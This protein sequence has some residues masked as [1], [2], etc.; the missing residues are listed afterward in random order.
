MDSFTIG[1]CRIGPD[2]PTFVIA[3]AG[4][5]H[6]GD[7]DLAKQL[8]DVA[9]DAGADAVKFQTFRAEDMYVED[10]G[11]VEYLDDDRSI[12]EIIESMEMPYE[13]IPELHEYCN[14]RG[15]LF[16]STPF[17]ERSAGELAEYVPAWKVASY[18]SSHHP[19]LRHLA[20]TE[21]PVIMSTGAHELGEVAESVDVLRE[22]GVSDLALLQCVAAYPTPLESINVRVVETLREQFGVPAGLSDHTLDPTVAPTAAVALGAAIIEKHFT[23]DKNMEGPDHQFALEP[24][25]LDRMVTAIRNT[26]KVLGDGAKS[27]LDVEEE[28]YQKARRS[29][30]AA[31]DIAAGETISR[32]DLSVLR[33]GNK[34]KGIHPKFVGD[35]VGRR[36]SK[37][38]PVEKGIEWG[39]IDQ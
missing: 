39:D 29:V 7:F 10:S 35:V 14:E 13:W 9:A 2:H 21:K 24:D 15:V 18:T 1:D 38:I 34:D 26:E 6:N 23:L 17:D 4:S 11:E 16:L 37:D 27:V 12:Y 25:G 36:A 31:R 20:D 28:L 5:N 32:D 3:E 33:P 19:F 22:A 30:H 8:I